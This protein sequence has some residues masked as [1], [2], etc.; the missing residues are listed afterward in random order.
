MFTGGSGTGWRGAIRHLKTRARARA[1]LL[2][3]EAWSRS[4]QQIAQ[5]RR[6]LFICLP[7][8]A[9]RCCQWEGCASPSKRL[10]TSALF[11]IRCTFESESGAL[12][13]R[14][15]VA[16]TPTNSPVPTQPV[17]LP[18]RTRSE[19]LW[20]RRRTQLHTRVTMRRILTT[21][22]VKFWAPRGLLNFL[23]Q[24]CWPVFLQSYNIPQLSYGTCHTRTAHCQQPRALPRSRGNN[25]WPMG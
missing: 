6:N 8:L 5:C 12:A 1:A 7:A 15:V 21:A 13:S 25:C 10:P 22:I 2:L 11:T 17:H 20:F 14:S 23:P 9:R 4:R 19:V 24:F 18:A 3:R 16:T